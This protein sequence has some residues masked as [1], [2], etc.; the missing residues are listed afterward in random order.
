M[1][2]SATCA[3]I[4]SVP[5]ADYPEGERICFRGARYGRDDNTKQPIR[6]C[7]RIYPMWRMVVHWLIAIAVV[8]QVVAWLVG[9]SGMPDVM[10]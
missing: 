3:V 9:Q 2:G 4:R 10:P 8:L 1:N 5:E 7:A 6:Q